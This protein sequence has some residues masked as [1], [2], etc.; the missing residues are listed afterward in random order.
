MGAP[1]SHCRQEFAVAGDP[2]APEQRD[3]AIVGSLVMIATRFS[4]IVVLS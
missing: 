3:E 2:P 1:E 4:V